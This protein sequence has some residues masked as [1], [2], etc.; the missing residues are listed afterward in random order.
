M[1]KLLSWIAVRTS[2]FVEVTH[3]PE[4]A[5][6]R[7]LQGPSYLLPLFI[8]G[9][10]FVVLSQ[11]QA[12]LT[13]QWTYHQLQAAGAPQEQVAA[14]VDLMR[15][16]QHLAT[17]LVPMLLFLRWLLFA[18]VLWLTSQLFLANV[19]FS[20]VLSVVAYS[21]IPILFRDAIVLFI[22]WMRRSD[23]VNQPEA[24]SAAIGLNLLLPHLRLPWSA[25]AGNINIFEC[26]YLCLLTVGLSKVSR[27][28]WQKALAMTAPAWIFALLVQFSIVSLGLSLQSSLG[29]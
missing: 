22:L 11:L 9:L 20:R 8:L 4:L 19:D 5:F 26:W 3:A 28:R 10:A 17:V 27:T 14:G 16:S 12:P 2:T 18:M 1:M 15:K 21:Y 29:R 24:L 23:A 25:L 7:N 13:I 6:A